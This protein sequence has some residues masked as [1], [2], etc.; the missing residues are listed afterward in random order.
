[1]CR[2]SCS[3]FGEIPKLFLYVEWLYNVLS[4]NT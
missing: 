1:M 4:Y 3:K 2:S